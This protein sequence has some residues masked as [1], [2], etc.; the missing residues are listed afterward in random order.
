[1]MR[2]TILQS[3]LLLL[4]VSGLIS[5]CTS[6]KQMVSAKSSFDDMCLEEITIS[7]L[8]AGYRNGCYTVKDVVAAYIDRINE[9][10]KNGPALNSIIMV[11]PDAI[12]IAEELDREIEGRIRAFAWHSC[13]V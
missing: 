1:M 13:C 6:H 10:D 3:L 5:D 8:Q 9:I 4:V 2:S 12:S 7:Q 11:N